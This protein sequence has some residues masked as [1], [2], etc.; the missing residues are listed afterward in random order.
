VSNK[1]NTVGD[2]DMLAIRAEE[3]NQD[4]KSQ[5]VMEKGS[6][7]MLVAVTTEEYATLR[8]SFARMRAAQRLANLQK[9]A[10]ESGVPAL[11]LEEVDAEIKAYRSE[12]QQGAWRK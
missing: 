5:I 4:F 12:R 11:S 1:Q 8:K 10:A 7:A 6:N 3:F 9:Q 2:D